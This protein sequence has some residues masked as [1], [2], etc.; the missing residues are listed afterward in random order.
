[1]IYSPLHCMQR[2]HSAYLTNASSLDV[3]LTAGLI[4]CELQWIVKT[5]ITGCVTA[6]QLSP[7]CRR[8]LRREKKKVVNCKSSCWLRLFCS[9]LIMWSIIL[10]EAA[11]RRKESHWGAVG[12][13]LHISVCTTVIG[14]A[15]ETHIKNINT[16]AI[17]GQVLPPLKGFIAYQ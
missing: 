11:L 10:A 17:M 1:M 3:F 9:N 8:G 2:D 15:G 13:R 5:T 4:Y 6:A 7:P 12:R 14:C 16:H